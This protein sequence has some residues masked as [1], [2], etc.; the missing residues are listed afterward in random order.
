M[1]SSQVVTRLIAQYKEYIAIQ[2]KLD[3]YKQQRILGEK[4]NR[5]LEE[6]YKTLLTQTANEM[7]FATPVIWILYKTRAY[8]NTPQALN[9]VSDLRAHCQPQGYICTKRYKMLEMYLGQKGWF[10]SNVNGRMKLEAFVRLP[11]IVA[12]ETNGEFLKKWQT[13]EYFKQDSTIAKWENFV[14]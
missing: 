11:A 13:Y 10:L 8:K 2:D 7:T 9:T 4:G 3:E 5:Q 14:K 6:F 1:N 12:L